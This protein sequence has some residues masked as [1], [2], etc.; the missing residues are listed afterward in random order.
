MRLKSIEVEN[1]VFT[2]IF[3]DD[4]SVVLEEEDLRKLVADTTEKLALWSIEKPKK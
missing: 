3:S 1:G 4:T 2:L